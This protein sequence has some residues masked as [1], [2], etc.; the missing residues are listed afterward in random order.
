MK[1]YGIIMFFIG[2]LFGVIE[3]IFYF[4]GERGFYYWIVTPLLFLSIG[5]IIIAQNNKDNKKVE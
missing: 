5:S 4:I 2:G 3:T 1:Y